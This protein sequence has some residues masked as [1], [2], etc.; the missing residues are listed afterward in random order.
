MMVEAL[1]IVNFWLKG[2]C[3]NIVKLGHNVPTTMCIGFNHFRIAR[4][5]YGPNANKGHTKASKSLHI[6]ETA[7]WSLKPF[8]IFR[9]PLVRG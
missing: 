5:R 1:N 4:Q 7:G 2:H 9:I 8:D 3:D 6:G